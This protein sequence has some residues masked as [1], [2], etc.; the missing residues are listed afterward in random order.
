MIDL[1]FVK[2]KIEEKPHYALTITDVDRSVRQVHPD[3]KKEPSM[4][5]MRYEW[6]TPSSNRF[7]AEAW[8]RTLGW[9]YRISDQRTEN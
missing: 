3:A 8:V 1:H 9:W 7:V 2:S 4:A 6:I 5:G